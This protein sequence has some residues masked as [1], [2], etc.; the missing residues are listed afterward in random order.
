MTYSEI[1]KELQQI[2]LSLSEIKPVKLES[3]IQWTGLIGVAQDMWADK[4]AKKLCKT[5]IIGEIDYL[6]LPFHLLL[7]KIFELLP[8]LLR[9]L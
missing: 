4:K 3:R 1:T 9:Y 8:F 7:K 2:K 5:I 6:N